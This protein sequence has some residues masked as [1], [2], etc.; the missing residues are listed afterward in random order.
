[1]PTQLLP[2]LHTNPN[3]PNGVV[4]LLTPS[5]NLPPHWGVIQVSGDDA[6]AFL[7]GQLS[8]NISA[9]HEHSCLAAWCDAKGRMLASM[10]VL[11][12]PNHA[13]AFLMLC[14]HDVI[15]AVLPR[16][17]MFVLRSKVVLEDASAD[18]CIHGILGEAA[19]TTWQSVAQDTPMDNWHCI[20]QH[21]DTASSTYIALPNNRVLLLHTSNHTPP[22]HE[23]PTLDIAA[24]TWAEI[25]SG[26]VMIEHAISSKYIPQMLNYE[27][28]GAVDFRKGCYPGQ[29][30]VAR[31]QF[32]GTIKR[33]AYIATTPASAHINVDDAVWYVAHDTP[34]NPLE[35]GFVVQVATYQD[36]VAIFAILQTRVVE[37]YQSQ[38]ID[39]YVE[40]HAKKYPLQLHD[41][42]Y[43]LKTSVA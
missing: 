2:Y 9:I 11:R 14:R 40:A 16:L 38:Q 32:R 13:H 28:V 20:R 15:T 43:S 41:L 26:I 36:T 1:M 8:N 5:G 30:V 31:T 33:R 25:A 10:V 3:H 18:Y 39:V 27:S 42:P 37:Q 12:D 24:W 29:E 23:Y 34:D 4:A 21:D 7:Q 35:C 22:P 6:Q 19:Q 17:K